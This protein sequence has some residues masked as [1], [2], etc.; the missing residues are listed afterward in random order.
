M[1][2]TK[3][4]LRQPFKEHRQATNNP[5]N[6]NATAAVLTHFHLPGHCAKDMTLIPVG[7]QYND[8]GTTDPDGK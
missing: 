4:L 7:L 1:G 2:E 8:P 6:S 3:C 5:N